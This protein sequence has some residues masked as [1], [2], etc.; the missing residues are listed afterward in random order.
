MNTAFLVGLVAGAVVVAVYAKAHAA[1]KAQ[2][3]TLTRPLN[4]PRAILADCD[5]CGRTIQDRHGRCSSCGSSAI[6]TLGVAVPEP[7][8]VQ[9]SA[10]LARVAYLAD[11][12]ARAKARNERARGGLSSKGVM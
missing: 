5:T 6:W 9:V 12:T 1:L 8:E 10:T 7:T 3:E 11:V 2:A 4:P